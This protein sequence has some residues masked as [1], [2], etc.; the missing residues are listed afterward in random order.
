MVK[1][2]VIILIVV[3]SIAVLG[4]DFSKFA[5]S[6]QTERSNSAK[7]SPIVES[8]ESPTA[9]ATPAATPPRTSL[10]DKLRKLKDKY[11]A[12]VK[13]LDIPELN[14]RLKKL[15]GQEFTSMKKY[16]NV[17]SPI[18]IEDDVLMTSGCEAHNCGPNRYIL[19]FD[20]NSDNLNVFHQEDSE[21]K[22]FFENGEIKLPKR[23][24]DEMFN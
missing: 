10:P 18:E 12:T 9:T 21:T 23:F 4:C 22:H 19:V 11:P 6:P 14:S 8:K 7:P 17:E 1:D 13:L 5:N 15:L 2:P 24:V 16:W 20:L 3:F